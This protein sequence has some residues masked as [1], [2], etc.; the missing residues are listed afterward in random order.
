MAQLLNE[1]V[2]WGTFEA[3][4]NTVVAGATLVATDANG[5]QVVTSLTPGQTSAQLTLG[6]GVWSVSIQAQDTNGL[7]IGN[8]VSDPL[9]FTV[10]AAPTTVTVS[11]PT[12]LHGEFVGTPV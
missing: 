5:V 9:T 3:P 6:V 11:I 10:V 12:N 7:P 8:A 1:T 2:T 4:L